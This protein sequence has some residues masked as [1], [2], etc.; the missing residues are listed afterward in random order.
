MVL[1]KEI[2]G[3]SV[4]LEKIMNTFE[5]LPITNKDTT[6]TLDGEYMV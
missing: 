6:S 3:D 5:S 1:L 2:C 4:T